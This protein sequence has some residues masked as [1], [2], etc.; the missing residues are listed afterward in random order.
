M[1]RA[2][3]RTQFRWFRRAAGHVRSRARV[4]VQNIVK[5]GLTQINVQFRGGTYRLPATV[6]FD[7][8][9]S[10]TAA[11]PIVYQNYPGESPVFSGG[12]R[13]T[14]W[15][16]TGGNTWKATLPRV[17]AA[18]SRTSFI[19]ESGGCGHGLVQMRRIL[20]G[21]ITGSRIRFI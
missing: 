20:W 21:L 18:I 7:G 2:A 8:T 12:M 17:H 15:T 6:M 11:M 4:A 5:T 3:G 14:N 10:G 16:N 9:D 13:V 1:E 19:T